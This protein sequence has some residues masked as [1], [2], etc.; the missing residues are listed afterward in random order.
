MNK[1]KRNIKLVFVVFSVLFI[2]LI[3]Y[4]TYFTAVER[5]RLIKSSYNRRL[6]EQEEKVM[7]GTIYDSKGRPLA[8]SGFEGETKKRIYNGGKALGPLIGYSD[9]VLGR[10]GI[11]SVFNGELL[12]IS[13]QDPVTL[14][15]QKI[16]GVSERGSDLYL[17]IDLDLQ[18]AAYDLFAGRKGALVALEP[19]TGRILA[20]V[21]SPGYDPSTVKQDWEILSKDENKPLINRATQGLYPPGS[22]F[23]IITLA[24]ALTYSPEIENEKFYTPGHI[25]VN[26]SIIRDGQ[27]LW[28]GE[29]DLSTAFRY[30]SN[31]VF[32]QIGQRVEREKMISMAD[33]FGFNT[34]NNSDIPI[35]KSTF[36]RPPIIGGNVE[37]AE[38]FI[39]QG[40]LLTT[41][42]QM[43]QVAAIIA[44][45]GKMVTPYIALK[46]VSPLGVEKH[47][48]PKGST[49]QVVSSQVADKI[50]ALMVDVVK[51]GTGTAAAINGIE[52]AGKTGSAENPHGKA[53]AWF[54]G[55]APAENPKIALAVIVENAGSGGAVAGPIA[56]GVILKYLSNMI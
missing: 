43:A 32:I 13:E 38:S 19:Q 47:T 20:L 27:H 23:K 54:V 28:P 3:I 18:R 17:T 36:P 2:S 9:P 12:G 49:T 11:E 21:S 56:R 44:N 8:E 16:L 51:N 26:G 50:K 14:L 15:R 35:A 6:W 30:S 41:P 25:K 5:E 37:M 34:S 42:F 24:S 29:Y 48:I 31:T 10:A 1:L 53:H 52:V 33:A 4:L 55:F 39:G 7:R 45:D 46:I 40:R 22:V